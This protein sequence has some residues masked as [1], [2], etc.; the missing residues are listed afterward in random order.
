VINCETE[1]ETIT[2]LTEPTVFPN[3]STG[4]FSLELPVGDTYEVTLTNVLGNTLQAFT[5]EGGKTIPLEVLTPGMYQLK[6]VN[7]SH[8]WST[9]VSVLK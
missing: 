2:T 6:A 3:P 4:L 8:V 7:G 9:R 1:L 5:T